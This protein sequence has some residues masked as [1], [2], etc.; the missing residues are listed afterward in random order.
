MQCFSNANVCRHHWGIV[1][2]QTDSGGLRLHPMCCVSDRISGDVNDAV[3]M[4][5]TVSRQGL[6]EGTDTNHITK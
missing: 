3:Y 2:M 1:K 6:V 4:G 5:H